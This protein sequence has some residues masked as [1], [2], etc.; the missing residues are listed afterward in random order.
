MKLVFAILMLLLGLG[1]M[2]GALAQDKPILTVYSYASFVGKYGPGA[3]V[4][5]RFEATCD[6]TLNWVATDD[7]GTLLARLKLEGPGSKA[8][9]ALGL[10]A[11]LVAEAGATGLF[12][13]HD[14]DLSGLDLPVAWTDRTFVPF[15]WSYLAFVYNAERFSRPPASLRE[16]VEDP[17]GP[18]VIIE[19]PRT[20]APGLGFLLW[21]QAVQGDQAGAGWSRLRPRIVTFTKGWSEAY[22]LFLKG[23][24]DMV[25]SYTTSPAY[26]VAVEKKSN[27]RAAAFAE[28]NYVHVEVAGVLKTARQPGL[29][30]AFIDFMLSDAF[31]GLMPEGNWMYP[32]RRP[33]AGLPA[34]FDGLAQ[35][36]RGLMIAPEAVRENRRS[37][38]DGWLAAT[39]R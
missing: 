18:T 13:P 26:H 4:K 38:T 11:N 2:T 30:R 5:E 14:R 10:D 28:G 12:A 6:C 36:P 32:V 37:W 15:D 17:K 1:P 21:M 29:A 9:V 39:N 20:S 23:E 7:A 22:G 16:L 34:S 24:A 27:F 8:D 19:D 3:R 35:P 33:A 31:Q 25:L